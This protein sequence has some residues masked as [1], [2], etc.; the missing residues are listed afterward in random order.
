[1]RVS[2]FRNLAG[3]ELAPAPGVNVISGD[4]GHGKTSLLEAIYF[5]ATSRSFRATRGAEL[6]RHEASAAV[7]HAWFAEVPT[8]APALTPREQVA[9]VTAR[10]TTVRM[11]GAKPK[12]LADYATQSPV[13]VFHVD[14]IGLSSGP[15]ARRRTLLDR[16]AL[17]VAPIFGDHRLRYAAAIRSRQRLLQ[18]PSSDPAHQAA[19]EAFE[20]LCALH[21]AA[22]TSAR[23]NATA[24]LA[25]ELVPAFHRIVSSDLALTVRYAPGGSTDLD[26]TR[27]ALEAARPRDAHR[28]S[29]GFGPHR[30]EL[31]L[32]LDG[33]PARLVASQGQHRALAIA[34]KAAEASA[35]AAARGVAPILLLDDLSSELDPRRTASLFALLGEAHGQLFLTTTRPE[36]IVT[37]P[38]GA[39][40]RRDF[41]LEHGAITDAS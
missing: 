39:A 12:T 3:L 9:A 16:L 13:V 8:D 22:V 17:F 26:L 21:G 1:L 33:R 2:D 20:N 31:E 34:M 27:K 38:L 37:S 35:I 30:D 23:A 14:E 4:N 10:G 36:L 7:S 18:S 19:L 32:Y 40:T 29:P 5:A 28:P 25:S 15:P 11:D 6:I 41:R 24:A